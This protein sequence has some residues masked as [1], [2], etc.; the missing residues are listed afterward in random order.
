M[1]DA[2]VTTAER[3]GER[4]YERWQAANAR[5]A[6]RRQKLEKVALAV[7]VL[8]VSAWAAVVTLL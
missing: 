1:I 4:R 2:A 6:K 5:S 8:A 7:M 3:G